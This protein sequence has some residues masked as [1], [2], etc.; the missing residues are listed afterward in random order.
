MTVAWPRCSLAA[1]TQPFTK[2]GTVALLLST[3]LPLLIAATWQKTK[4]TKSERENTA[5]AR[6]SLTSASRAEPQVR[7]KRVRSPSAHPAARS[8]QQMAIVRNKELATAPPRTSTRSQ[9]P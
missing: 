7:T 5:G 4:Q 8:A 1:E 9:T 2:G 6:H 3:V